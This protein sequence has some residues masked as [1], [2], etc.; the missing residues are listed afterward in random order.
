MKIVTLTE[1]QYNNIL[2]MSDEII[3]EI[4]GASNHPFAWILG[5]RGNLRQIAENLIYLKQEFIKQGE[6]NNYTYTTGYLKS[7][8]DAFQRARYDVAS[9]FKFEIPFWA[10][11]AWEKI[12]N[13]LKRLIEFIGNIINETMKLVEIAVKTPRRVMTWV[14]IVVGGIVILL[15]IGAYRALSKSEIKITE[16]LFKKA[17]TKKYG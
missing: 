3:A 9:V 14:P 10:K 15:G 13:I 17:L 12:T 5:F 7:Y 6:K 2:K 1:E 16:G 4:L 8:A 11:E